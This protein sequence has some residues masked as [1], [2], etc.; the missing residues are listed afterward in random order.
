[1]KQEQL[2]RAEKSAVAWAI[3]GEI[4]N[5]AN[6]ESETVSRGLSGRAVHQRIETLQNA[7]RKL[8]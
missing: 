5:L 4:S 2:T 7:L 3:L 1:M 6:L 8:K